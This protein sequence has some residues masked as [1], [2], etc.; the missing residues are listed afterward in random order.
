MTAR[1]SNGS[2][3]I[4]GVRV[5]Y[6]SNDSAVAAFTGGDSE[7]TTGSDGRATVDMDAGTGLATVYASGA[8]DGDAIRV[9]VKHDDN[10]VRYE[11][12]EDSAFGSD[13]QPSDL[14]LDSLSPVETGTVDRFDISPR[15]RGDDFAFKYTAYLDVPTGGTYTLYTDSDDGSWLYIDGSQ[16]VDNGGEHSARERSGTV[17][18]SAGRHNVTVYVYENRGEESLQV[19]WNGPG[20]S[21]QEVP[22]SV[23]TPRQPSSNDGG[24]GGG[25]GGGTNADVMSLSSSDSFNNGGGPERQGM[26]F[27]LDN[28]GSSS[29]TITDIAVDSTSSSA[30]RIR[31]PG[32]LEFERTDGAGSLDQQMNIDGTTYGLDTDATITSGGSATFELKNLQQV[33]GGPPSDVDMRGES[34]TITVH[35]ADGSSEQFTLA[36]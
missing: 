23:L 35:Y 24:T 15:N 5:D 16:V 1:A 3:S 26:E 12:Y 9:R 29:V 25:G 30:N 34:V 4:E 14:G 22:E 17:T 32:D 33:G 7:G 31:L 20:L 28:G 13:D 36:G 6:A 21:K 18:L 27:T 8:E 10:G 19:S 11:Y 2:D